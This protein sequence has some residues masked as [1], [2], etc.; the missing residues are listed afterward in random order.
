MHSFIVFIT[1]CAIFHHAS[2]ANEMKNGLYRIENR[3][4]NLVF[5]IYILCTEFFNVRSYKLF[6]FPFM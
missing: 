6:H 2:A 3:E 5:F 1:F 4:D